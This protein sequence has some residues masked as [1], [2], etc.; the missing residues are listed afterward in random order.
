MEGLFTSKEILEYIE[1]QKSR[2]ISFTKELSLYFKATQKDLEEGKDNLKLWINYISL[3]SSDCEV[4]EIREIFKMLK[5]RY[6]KC[7]EYWEAFVGFEI[8]IRTP[9]E[10]EEKVIGSSLSFLGTKEFGD[11]ERVM[12]YLSKFSA[13]NLAQGGAGAEDAA[14]KAA[15]L[16]RGCETG[17]KE[18]GHNKL[19]SDRESE[20]PATKFNSTRI[21]VPFGG[22]THEVEFDITAQVKGLRKNRDP[23]SFP[24]RKGD[25]LC[26]P[27][28]VLGHGKHGSLKKEGVVHNLMYP[29]PTD[30]TSNGSGLLPK[31]PAALDLV[32]V[33][34]ETMEIPLL[35]FKGQSLHVIRELGKGGSS[36]VYQVLHNDQIFALKRV[37]LKEEQR[38]SFIDEI[39][40]LQRLRGQKG[41]IELV[42]HDL[43]ESELDLLLECGDTDLGS[44]IRS[45]AL[46]LNFIKDIW[47]QILR[48]VCLVHKQRIIHKDL[49]PAN[50]LFVKGRLK[51]IDFGI[52]KEIKSDTTKVFNEAQ[53]GTVN[54]MS[55]E[56]LDRDT[57]LGRSTDVWSLGCILYEMVYGHTPLGKYSNVVQKIKKLQEEEVAIE[58]PET[59]FW[60]MTAVIKRCLVKDRARRAMVEELL[61]ERSFVKVTVGELEDLVRRVVSGQRPL[62]LVKDFVDEIQARRQSGL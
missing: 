39:K 36:K 54:Y 8:K 57:K 29:T 14:E 62:G 33:K 23:P 9:K 34:L 60:E 32:N 12:G 21:R 50:F 22:K 25:F 19:L 11:K 24:G 58:Y 7:L 3:L 43:R 17:E 56:S 49:K 31:R 30:T 4:T 61:R 5:L 27:S 35:I 47:E 38:E 45:N 26:E 53:I 51:L 59:P 46:T 55:P 1:S 6:W 40:L 13:W 44:V 48:I 10:F 16:K 15:F 2:G 42:D 20:R 37:S 28:P 18:N 52:S 41:I